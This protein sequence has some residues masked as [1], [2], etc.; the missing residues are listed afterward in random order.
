MLKSAK[1][2]GG[3]R[4]NAGRPT[5]AEPANSRTIRLTDEHWLKFKNIGGVSWLKSILNDAQE[6][7]SSG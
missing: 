7:S 6:K 1:T 2:R 5:I 3:A 4:L